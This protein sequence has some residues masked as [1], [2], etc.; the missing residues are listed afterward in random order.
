MGSSCIAF[1][2]STS[3]KP[4]KIMKIIGFLCSASHDCSLGLECLWI[5]AMS[6][7]LLQG[8]LPFEG[9]RVEGPFHLGLEIK[10]LSMVS[11]LEICGPK[12]FRKAS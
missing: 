2:V 9:F 6:S 5:G 3:M 11:A 8:S 7:V 4:C 1:D 10:N 12:N